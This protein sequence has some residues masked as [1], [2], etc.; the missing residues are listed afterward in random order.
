MARQETVT[1]VDDLDGSPGAS[2]TTFGLDGRAYDIDLTEKNR[3]K[4]DAILAPFIAAARRARPGPTPSARNGYANGSTARRRPSVD[5]EQNQAIR[6]WAKRR[7]LDCA[8]RGRIPAEIMDAYR[9]EHDRPTNGTRIATE[10]TTVVP[11]L[12]AQRIDTEPEPEPV[13]VPAGPTMY[14][15]RADRNKVVREWARTAGVPCAPRGAISD[16]VLAKFEAANGPTEIG[17]RDA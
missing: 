9:E 14:A 11:D 16:D 2:S 1:I 5:R 12:P 15:T 3:A 7:G 10:A 17:H 8:D 6:D 4:L 13:T